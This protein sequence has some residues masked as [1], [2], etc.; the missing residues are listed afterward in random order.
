MKIVEIFNFDS[1]LINKIP[2]AKLK[3]KA[4]RPEKGGLTNLK[5]ETSL[6][7]TFSDLETGLINL[8]HQLNKDKK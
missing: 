5:A 4:V 7:M 1:D 2:S 6:N 8:K 3:Q